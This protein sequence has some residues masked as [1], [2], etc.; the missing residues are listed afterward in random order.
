[1]KFNQKIITT[2]LII[3]VFFICSNLVFAQS[4]SVNSGANGSQSA[5]SGQSGS[6]SLNTGVGGSQSVNTGSSGT[7]NNPLNAPDLQTLLNEVLSYVIVLGSILLTI[8]LVYVGFKFVTAQG[9]PEA[10]SS[11]KTMLLW[12]VIGGVLLLG[13]KAIA[14]VIT[15]TASSL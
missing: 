13:A 6:N 1:M 14:I 2:S 11:A 9:N 8:M 3:G 15:S 10:V 7:L 12:T 4:Q 5:N